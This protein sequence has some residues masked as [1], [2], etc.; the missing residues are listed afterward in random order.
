M[1]N[2]WRVVLINRGHM[3]RLI[4]ILAVAAAGATA[5]AQNPKPAVGTN[6]PGLKPGMTAP[7]P[8]VVPLGKF[9]TAEEQGSYA[10][11]MQVA[12]NIR[13][14]LKRSGF[15]VNSA[16]LIQGFTDSFLGKETLVSS[17]DLNIV[18]NKFLQDLRTKADAKRKEQADANK[19]AGE[20]FLADNK[21]KDGVVTLPDG[22]QYKVVRAGDGAKPKTNDVV[23]VQYRGTLLNGTEFDSSYTRGQPAS[24]SVR[25]VIKGWTEALQLMGVGSK[26]ELW[27]PADLAYGERGSPPK[28]GPG[29]T[30]HFEIELVS[31][32]ESTPPPMPVTSDIIK[33]PSQ[34]DLKKGAKIE[35]LKPED[36]A[37]LQK[38][39]AA[40]KSAA[41][42]NPANP[43]KP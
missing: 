41:G 27:V 21:S 28:I 25:G 6:L 37:R 29:E 11:G 15:E 9:A 1:L 24:F 32:K 10:M 13:N 12:D 38:E 18:F 14:N 22:L 30:L 2:E 16:Q 34:D 17:N 42:A 5:L 7:P 19:K 35:V 8:R 3:K 31:I 33:V 36:V 26:W 43:Q 20:A 40:K 23:N 4:S 39:E